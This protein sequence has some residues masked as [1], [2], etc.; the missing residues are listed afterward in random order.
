MI[1]QIERLKNMNYYIQ[2]KMTGSPINFSK[3]INVSKRM[4]FIYINLLKELGAPIKYSQ[5]RKTYYYAVEG[6]F[7]IKFK[8]K[9]R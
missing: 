3:K 5:K 4:L 2:F 7:E 1:E 6:S 8:E 9:I